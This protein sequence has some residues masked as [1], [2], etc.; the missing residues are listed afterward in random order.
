MLICCPLLSAQK[1]IMTHFDH[2]T[3]K[4]GL[5][6]DYVTGLTMDSFGHIWASTQ[7]GLNRFDGTTFKQFL[8]D[9]Y[10]SLFRNDGQRMHS[11]SNGRVLI[12]GYLGM[13]V[14]YNNEKD[15][16]EDLTPKDFDTTYYKEIV[17]FHRS[18]KG[19]LYV[20]TSSGIYIY[21]EEKQL[22]SNDFPAF[23]SMKPFFIRSL[24]V[25]NFDR[26]WISS[27]NVLYIF[28]KEGKLIKKIDLSTGYKQMFISSI[29]QMDE[30]TLLVSSFSDI[31]YYFKIGENG[32]ITQSE[33]QKTP[34]Y[35]L[36][37]MLRDR[38]GNYWFTSDGNGLWYANKIPQKAD[39]YTK[40]MPYDTEES[41]FDKIYTITEDY[42]GNIWVGT[43]N[44]GI[45]KCKRNND[46]VVITSNNVRYPFSTCCNFNE[47]SDGNL[48][49]ASDGGGMTLASPD[50]STMKHFNIPNKNVINITSDN[51]ENFWVTTWGGGLY[52]YNH[53]KGTISQCSFDGLR[54]NLNCFFSTTIMKNGEVWACTAG[55]GIYIRDTEGKWKRKIPSFPNLENDQW[56]YKVVEGRSD[57][58]WILTSRS[59]WRYRCGDLKP[60]LSDFSKKKD[61]NPLSVNDAVCDASGRIFVATSK[62]VIT[63]SADGSECDTLDYVPSGDYCSICIGK[64]SHIYVSGTNGI[65]AIDYDAKTCKP[66]TIDFTG[67]GANYFSQRSSFSDSKGRL[68]FGCND[69]F[70]SFDPSKNNSND[71]IRHFAFS[72]LFISEKKSA[73]YGSVLTSG[74][75][76]QTKEIRLN[77]DNTDI[78]IDIDLID[79]SGFKA[80]C[81]YRLIGLNDKWTRVRENRKISFSY[82]PS[83]DYTLEVRAYKPD[84]PQKAKTISL[85]IV[86]LPPWWKTWWFLTI[87]A[88]LGCSI[89]AYA[90]NHRIKSITKQK[91]IL[92]KKVK[93]RTKELNEANQEISLQNKSLK[94]NQMLIEMKNEE[95]G[96]ALT[97]K[98]HLISIIAH[99]LKNPMFGIASTMEHL[100]K[101]PDKIGE[102]EKRKLIADVAETSK[103]LQMELVNL[104]KWASSQE[105][106]MNCHP[107]STNLQVIIKD[108][109]SFFKNLLDEKSIE[110]SYS[111]E[112]TSEAF[113]DPRM[114]GVVIRNL[115]ANSIK[116]TPNNGKISVKTWEEKNHIF[117]S[118]RDNG[119]GMTNE[120]KQNIFSGE[121]TLGTNNEKGTGLG[122]ITCKKMLEL[123]NSEINIES[124]K[125]NG[126]EIT[127]QMPTSNIKSGQTVSADAKEELLAGINSSLLEEANILIVEDDSLIR[128][129]IRKLLEQFMVVSEAENG[130]AG[131]EKIKENKPDII[132]SDV[133]MPIMDGIAFAKAIRKQDDLKSVPFLFLSAR[134]SE[135]DRIAGLLSGA[136]DYLAKPFNDNELLI[137]LCNILMTQQARTKQELSQQMEIISEGGAMTEEVNKEVISPMLQRVMETIENRYKDSN[138]SI[139]DICNDLDMSQSTLNR[140]L[141]ML[142]GKTSNIIINEYRLHKA[143]Y[144][145]EHSDMN[146]SEIAYE[147]GFNDPHYFSKKFK[148]HFGTSP[149]KSGN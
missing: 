114:I 85:K 54:T 113:V 18:S 72:D 13:L 63:F 136:I 97:S 141:K 101:H 5:S 131:L 39:D 65:M 56:V 60:L 109:L 29:H 2:Y 126:T 123:N 22:F 120:Q 103:S 67:K 69:G 50:F 134:N 70:L 145:L 112:A 99:D 122:L 42:K 117:V 82:I 24:Y 20:C 17:S 45:W 71:T 127:I 137:K 81:D 135:S 26:Y 25:D 78:D 11:L 59:I 51:H 108:N 90:I 138:F 102:E 75:I 9:E 31:I 89:I 10:P 73:P 3:V 98:D 68:F 107:T 49:I 21:D 142:T 8:T 15:L 146:V 88:I 55:D 61:H 19:D 53:A 129:H 7:C 105:E 139:D 144:L 64:D 66:Y 143:K 106:E 46:Q 30:S 38:Q 14:R 27:F 41:S 116:F 111:N 124:E 43:K 6:S 125:G 94:E 121:S 91:E 74:N 4:D 128:L 58:R 57:S 119:V 76:A 44:S 77:H 115:I 80:L 35:N 28:S 12:G 79:Y 140:K 93:E 118:V 132:L 147:V 1:Q 148:A 95:L 104:L 47:T 34:F 23:N 100:D 16:F 149:S 133:E 52:I 83:G 86:V 36:S 96:N 92:E 62:S 33:P 84:Q 130:E 48:L 40:I 32:E 37:N 87:M 110:L